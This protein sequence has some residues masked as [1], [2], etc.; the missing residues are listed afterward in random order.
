MLQF[1]LSWGLQTITVCSVNTNIRNSAMN[2]CSFLD[3]FCS[4]R[5]HLAKATLRP[6]ALVL[7]LFSVFTL[8]FV[9]LVLIFCCGWNRGP[10]TLWLKTKQIYHLTV[11]DVRSVMWVSLDESQRAGRAALVS[12]DVRE[13]SVFLPSMVCRDC[14]RSSAPARLPPSSKPAM[15]WVLLTAS[16]LSFLLLFSTFQDPCD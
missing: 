10:W 1:C 8:S 13:N 4:T 14:W 9:L 3:T 11:G 12:E 2:L 16:A 15:A 7:V 6:K 5:G